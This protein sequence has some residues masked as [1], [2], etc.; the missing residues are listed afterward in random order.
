MSKP[1]YEVYVVKHGPRFDFRADYFPRGFA[2]QSGAFELCSEMASKG[3]EGVCVNVPYKNRILDLLKK[4]EPLG[5][6]AEQLKKELGTVRGLRDMERAGLIHYKP[7]PI[8]PATGG[9]WHAGP[10]PAPVITDRPD[11]TTQQDLDEEDNELAYEEAQ[12][13][14]QCGKQRFK[15]FVLE[16]LDEYLMETDGQG[17][18]YFDDFLTKKAVAEDFGLFLTQGDW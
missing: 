10:A 5:V 12:R 7:N 16:C 14:F 13:K 8:W 15:D 11:G 6:S 1:K 4:K 2:L 3:G 18:D 17:Y 9:R